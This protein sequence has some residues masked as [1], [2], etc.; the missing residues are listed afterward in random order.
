M[1]YRACRMRR[2]PVLKRRCWETRQRPA[3]D[4]PWEGESAQELVRRIVKERGYTAP[5]LLDE[6]GDVTG[7]V[8]GV[9]GPPTVYFVDRRG[10][11]TGRVVG[12]RDWNSPAG[13]KFID[14]L[15]GARYSG[16]SLGMQ[17]SVGAYADALRRR[18]DVGP[19]YHAL[20]KRE[21]SDHLLTTG[22]PIK[23]RRRLA[24]PTPLW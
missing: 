10:N 7:R 17:D 22:K 2:P 5:V 20:V 11:L 9:F 6:T 13:H 19:S 15:L 18:R 16:R 12:P 14:E 23:D 3:L 8:Y 24:W 1:K 21:R 4:G